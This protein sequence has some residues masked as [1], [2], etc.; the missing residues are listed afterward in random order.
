MATGRAI[1]P[2]GSYDISV[3]RYLPNG[4]LDSSF[5]ADG[6][7]LI[8]MGSSNDIG[9]DVAIDSQNR[10][11]I[12]GTVGSGTTSIGVARLSASGSL[13]KSFSGSGKLTAQIDGASSSGRATLIQPDGKIVVAGDTYDA[14]GNDTEFAAIR[15]EPTGALDASFGVEGVVSVPV[16]STNDRADAVAY[17]GGGN[18]LLA[19]ATSDNQNLAMAR[20][21]SVPSRQG[22]TDFQFGNLGYTVTN[23]FAVPPVNDILGATLETPLGIYVA[24]NS[25][26]IA[27]DTAV[28]RV[29]LARFTAAGQLDTSF[30]SGT[31]RVLLSTPAPSLKINDLVYNQ[32]TNRIYA[33]G[34]AK[35]PTGE[36]LQFKQQFAIACFNATTGAPVLA[37]GNQGLVL[38]AVGLFD[39]HANSLAVSPVDGQVVVVGGAAFTTEGGG[40]WAIV[41]YS[42]NGILMP[43]KA[44]LNVSISKFESAIDVSFGAD[45]SFLVGGQSAISGGGFLGTLLYDPFL[46]RVLADGTPDNTLGIKRFAFN[47]AEW[48]RSVRVGDDLHV[49]GYN[50]TRNQAFSVRVSGM[51]VI[52]ASSLVEFPV[53]E[54]P[55]DMFRDTAGRIM[56][57]NYDSQYGTRTFQRFRPD[58]SYDPTFKNTG[59]ATENA[60]P[61]DLLIDGRFEALQANGG[62]LFG[63]VG[64]K[65]SYGGTDF[66]VRRITATGD[67]DVSFG[68]N[69]NATAD[70]TTLGTPVS[71][72][73][74]ATVA[75][76]AP[77]N[78]LLIAGWVETALR[79]DAGAISRFLENGE[80][81]SSFGTAG[82]ITLDL[83]DQDDRVTALT[84]QA[85]D[86]KVVAIGTTNGSRFIA[87]FLPDGQ[88]DKEFGFGD[89]VAMMPVSTVFKNPTSV[90]IRS[91]GKILVGGS[92]SN[93]SNDDFAVACFDSTTGDL[94]PTFD[95]AGVAG[96]RSFDFGSGNDAIN[97]MQLD[98]QGRLI[99]IGSAVV[100]GRSQFAI[101]RLD[102][103][104]GKLDTSFSGDGLGL[105]TLF[106]KN[107]VA[108]D[109]AVDSQ[110]NPILAGYALS[111][112]GV[113]QFAFAK[114]R[115]SDGQLDTSFGTQGALQRDPVGLNEPGRAVS[116]EL[117][118]DGKIVYTGTYAGLIPVG[119][120][121]AD[122][123]ADKSFFNANGVDLVFVGNGSDTP[124]NV[125][126]QGDA[127]IKVVGTTDP[128]SDDDGDFFIYQ[129]YG[130]RPPVTSITGASGNA[131]TPITFTLQT[132]DISGVDLQSGFR[133]QLD[134]NGD[135]ITD[136]TVTGA[137]S[138][139]V[140]H[141]FTNPQVNKIRVTATELVEGVPNG[142]SHSF[143]RAVQINYRPVADAINTAT[144]TGAVQP[145]RLS[146]NDNNPEVAQNLT[147][148]ITEQPSVGTLGAIYKI[149][150]DSFVNY[151]PPAGYKGPASFK[152]TVTDD[153]SA[154]GSGLTSAPVT[155]NIRVEN[156]GPLVNINIFSAINEGQSIAFTGTFTDANPGDTH[157]KKLW[158]I[159]TEDRRVLATGTG[160]SITYTPLQSGTYHVV[161]DV[162]D[163][164]GASGFRDAEFVV[165]NVAPVVGINGSSNGVV[166]QTR[167]FY[168]SATDVNAFDQ[169][170]SFTYFINFGDGT[171]QTVTGAAR[172]VVQHAY[173]T[174]GTYTVTLQ[175]I[176]TGTQQA[177]AAVTQTVVISSASAS[178]GP[179]GTPQEVSPNSLL[180]PAIAM[181]ADGTYVV[182]WTQLTFGST[183][184]R[185][186]FFRRFDA[187]GNPLT[188]ATRA[189]AIT[190]DLQESPAIGMNKDGT[191]VIAWEH[192]WN[193]DA[194]GSSFKPQLRGRLFNAQGQP[195]G[196]ELTLATADDYTGYSVGVDGAGN[197]VVGWSS[198]DVGGFQYDIHAQ[199]W[200]S[201]G[202]TQGSQIDLTPSTDAT[203]I[204]PAISVNDSGAFI[205]GYRESGNTNLYA[206]IF[207]AS[208]VQQ[209]QRIS[210]GSSSFN[211]N[212]GPA[213]ALRNN[214]E[215]IVGYSFSSAITAVRFAADGSRIGGQVNVEADNPASDRPG[216]AVEPD[217]DFIVSWRRNSPGSFFAR[218]FVADGT[219][220]GNAFEVSLNS[221][222]G[223][224]ELPVAT[225]GTVTAFL[226]GTQTQ[227]YASNQGPQTTDIPP[228]T[229][230]QGSAPTT[231][232]LP[233]YFSDAETAA[234]ALS[235]SIV[236]VTGTSGL[237]GSTT[238]NGSNQLVL[239]YAPGKTGAATVTI[240]AT[241]RGGATVDTAL[242][243]TV[244]PVAPPT[245]T[246]DV[247]FPYGVNFGRIDRST[248]QL[249]LQ[250]NQ[251]M[252]NAGTASHYELRR[253]GTNGLLESSD[254]LIPV[255]AAYDVADQ[256]VTLTF[257][258]LVDDT[259]RL[260]VK[261][262]LTNS[263]GNALDG[264]NN[265]TAG[266]DYTR[267]FVVV[268]QPN[269]TQA[270]DYFLSPH[271]FIFDVQRTGAGTGQLIQ[272][273]NDAFDGALKLLVDGNT[274]GTFTTVAQEFGL[275][276][277]PQFYSTLQVQRRV[278]V[279]PTGNDDFARTIDIFGSSSGGAPVPMT[280]VTNLSGS[281][282]VV[283]TSDGDAVLETTDTWFMTDD[284]DGSGSPAMIQLIHSQMGLSPSSI[285]QTGD[286]VSWTFNLAV[287]AGETAR[288]AHFTVQADT[289]A[290]AIASANA[291][292]TSNGFG[293][294]AA[295]K[296]DQSERLSIANFVFG[297]SSA[298]LDTAGKLTLTDTAA[299]GANNQIA[300]DIDGNGNLVVTDSAAQ[301]RS[302]PA[303]AAISNGD[304][305]LT[306]PISDVFGGATLNGAAGNDSLGI[307][308][309]QLDQLALSG[310]AFQGGTGTD[311]LQITG[312]EFTLDLTAL[313]ND[314]LTGIEQLDITGNGNNT[315]ILNQAEVLALSAESKT[316]VVRRNSGDT[317][318]I[319]T[320]WSAS[321]FE[322]IGGIVFEVFTQGGATL[323]VQAL[324]EIRVQSPNSQAIVDE[325]GTTSTFGVSLTAP[326]TSNVVVLLTSSDLTE[327]TVST[328]SLT[329][330]PANW[331]VPQTVTATGVNDV[332]ID[333]TQTSKIAIS[334]VDASSENRFDTAPDQVVNVLTTDND[335]AGFVITE[336]NGSTSVGE[337]G[338]TDTVTVAL[339]AQPVANVVLSVSSG[340]TGEMTVSPATLTFTPAN[341][342][343]PQTVTVAGVTDTL[344]DGNQTSP[345][346]ISVSSPGSSAF[347]AV[348]NQVVS[349]TTLD[350]ADFDIAISLIG[351]QQVA[352]QSSSG[353]LQVL[354]DNVIAPAY[355]EFVASR[356]Q[357]ITITGDVGNNL[358]DLRYVT[359]AAF[360]RVAGVTV[361]VQGGAGNDTV[362][363]SA[364][365][366]NISGDDG[367]DLLDGGTG[368]DSLIG[369]AGND[370]LLGALGDDTLTGGAGID[371]LSAGAGGLDLLSE[372]ALGDLTLTPTQMTS[373]GGGLTEVDTL[374]D[375]ERAIVFGGS[376]A[377]ILDASAAMFPVTLFGGNGNDLLIGGSQ[378]D[379]LDGQGGNDTVTGNGAADS[380]MG[381]AGNDTLREIIDQD[382]TLTNTTLVASGNTKPTVTDK[383]TAF[384]IAEI[385]GGLSRN[386]IDLSGFAASL[387]TTIN[388]GGQSDTIFGSPGPDVIFTLTGN[389]SISGLGGA[390][391][392]VSGN[393]NDTIS[394][395]DGADNLNGQNGN[396]LV[397]GDADN[398]VVV[399]GAGIDTLNGGAGHDFV[400][401]QTEAGL[402]S[403]GDGNDTVQ[404]N[405]ANDTLNGDAGDD[406]LFGL[407]GDDVLNGGDGVDSLV[408]AIGNDSLN[409]GAGTDTLQGDLGNDTLD[410]G[411]DFDRINEVFDTNVTIVGIAV[412]TSAFGVDSVIA[413]E[414]IQIAGGA[415]NNFFD[416]RSA[417]VPVFLSGGS[418]ND[419]LLGGSKADGVVGGD[420][421]DVLSGGAGAD[422]I[423]GGAGNDYWLE[424]ADTN[425]TVN[426]TVITSA[427]SGSETPTSIERIALIGGVGANK[428]DATL[429]TVPVVLI[430]GRGS[431][432]LL[433]GSAADTLSGGNRNDATVSGGDGT[434]SLDGGAGADVLENDPVDAR[435]IG[436]GDT[437]VADVFTLLP[438]WI[439]SL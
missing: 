170:G 359:T 128:T 87:R 200:S 104:T 48:I 105:V 382:L 260:I 370:Q 250:F 185:D 194:G 130:D 78:N 196:S 214:G 325:S 142:F 147:F 241:D 353:K 109:V 343:V 391:V 67:S 394:G 254:P 240:R 362:L 276:T 53:L 54:R 344:V 28:G 434:D 427:V 176:N 284:A 167:T 327:L 151:T 136:E 162:T 33:V 274:F 57:T 179:V 15:F 428:L 249:V 137:A 140:T 22:D 259:Y 100:S 407:Q 222:I 168:L 40:D 419:T 342:N 313:S 201:A 426:G 310:F 397:L 312:A 20:L 303:R 329:F 243:V 406:R 233:A 2:S 290:A 392:V 283:T 316:L 46:I 166:N 279:T 138:K 366:D 65:H 17:Q 357:S 360:T 182:V 16:S 432:T 32:A 281:T 296:L 34:Y 129:L 305:T 252:A 238:I 217:G 436:A 191:F 430:G 437:M 66:N 273:K 299:A 321:T 278:T 248:T 193:S 363:G 271:G 421:D 47:G 141:T 120:L 93:G 112:G 119:R 311:A 438:S 117:Q 102:P 159:L 189:N 314:R 236:S 367:N 219:P 84:V 232:N 286:N 143:Q 68:L 320:G 215:F 199:R 334:V 318:K 378:I 379:Q 404:G 268:A 198:L 280:Y 412:S 350:N 76:A 195:Q 228:V 298:T 237:F 171:N 116:L 224:N 336:S 246:A 216:L 108:L 131:G 205:L 173:A 258:A 263:F 149:G 377:N 335:F 381:G 96:V 300:L 19:G 372:S 18:I 374:S 385:S 337:T 242:Q 295:L 317:V 35:I 267:D 124:S 266:G 14:S 152:Y 132:S 91:D 7:V 181:A 324:F 163:N 114:F 435:I 425:F 8:D 405:T 355:S 31:G 410:G 416:A 395:G 187:T 328:T 92:V 323:K 125:V 89:G 88:L 134:W 63:T 94:D 403:G 348:S 148:T 409:G 264:D 291:L 227:T 160:T 209:G 389:D 9:Y 269:N 69:G 59:F 37:W 349:V 309:S 113:E 420:G 12:A 145:I 239:T 150:T 13:D 245:V 61:A 351:S 177:S 371:T 133:Y 439:D 82:R 118:S 11:V 230:Q 111:S 390:D 339:T 401:G 398:D 229:V 175:A 184:D 376:T 101:A 103:N 400:A 206:H 83:S 418:G 307:N 146:G 282:A 292:V 297:T 331:N 155:A 212:T 302:A 364:F 386:R 55:S 220:A 174:P 43:S 223:S 433:G 71:Y 319:G 306:L 294:Q 368:N 211:S 417:T 60:S 85:S 369:G 226:Q 383:L 58:G 361:S 265:G 49:L 157:P 332:I 164:E 261:S 197:F 210:V 23:Y 384:E 255:Q 190:T 41:R 231:L 345:L 29:A 110:N 272:G 256:S 99:A 234:I 322:T 289:R 172:H 165:N 213:L 178:E 380:L 139:Q 415:T 21:L 36:P 188:A 115:G 1:G 408:G 413:I 127:H 186:V 10:I 95:P 25:A 24:G 358:V 161:Y 352:L 81:D 86:G 56:I 396:D 74:F 3:A 388:G 346:V 73:N 315:L 375:L 70:F 414:R 207:N 126:I 288:L 183:I 429:A 77:D 42:A 393:G 79:G 373:N 26:L 257:D 97:S 156:A 333:D 340:D 387:G 411:A 158:T 253:T 208:G 326:P 251:A 277:E 399:G 107:A 235:Y 338:T 262:A 39:S 402:L 122:G 30:G 90:V 52:D 431:D 6:R 38:T 80:L 180:N 153:A 347:E 106:G 135:G 72:S 144:V 422:I 293:G 75:Y 247:A 50:Q 304:K 354:V 169:T 330:T 123:S 27:N 192:N 225:N 221:F 121:N 204:Y 424:K 275:I 154:G 45:G 62:I 365:G 341:W 287:P 270:A 64:Y 202:V 218:R 285:S 356:I 308:G 301:F 4:G 51:G 203:G 98:G 244:V 44:I 423:D 5:D